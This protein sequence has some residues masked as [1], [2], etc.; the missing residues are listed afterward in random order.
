MFVFNQDCT[1]AAV[2]A[3]ADSYGDKYIGVF[4]YTVAAGKLY[5]YPCDWRNVFSHAVGN[6]ETYIKTAF[7]SR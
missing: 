7:Y 2:P 6:L 5:S 3:F 4:D 1:R